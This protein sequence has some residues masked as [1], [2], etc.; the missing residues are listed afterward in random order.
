MLIW[1]RVAPP[2]QRLGAWALGCTQEVASQRIEPRNGWSPFGFPFIP[3]TYF[4]LGHRRNWLL[5]HSNC[6]GPFSTPFRVVLRETQKKGSP[7]SGFPRF[8]FRA[9]PKRSLVGN[10]P[11]VLE[12]YDGCTAAAAGSMDSRE[13]SGSFHGYI[14]H[15]PALQ[16]QHSFLLGILFAA[17]PGAKL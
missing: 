11:G 1:C 14:Q 6:L 9:I 15:P 13:E 17:V 10:P 2:N 7:I 12:A 16:G 4:V 3:C 5:A 8:P